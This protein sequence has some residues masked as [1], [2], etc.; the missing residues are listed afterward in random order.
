LS[1]KIRRHDQQSQDRRECQTSDQEQEQKST[2]HIPVTLQNERQE[3][4]FS[5]DPSTVFTNNTDDLSALFS[6]AVPT[7]DRQET[8]LLEGNKASFVGGKK[9]YS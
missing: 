7:F 2:T 5:F 3:S 8:I 1:S 9:Y 6:D 4:T